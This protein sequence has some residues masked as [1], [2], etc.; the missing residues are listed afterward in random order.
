VP[1]PDDERQV[2]AD[3]FN[4]TWVLLETPDRTSA[5]DE[6]M[7]HAAHASRFHW[8]HARQPENLAICEDADI[9]EFV[10][11]AAYEALTRASLVA[12]DP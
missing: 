11:A 7:V 9:R 6:E 3:L 1:E 4:R 8:E 10:R 12:G 2:A 5:Q